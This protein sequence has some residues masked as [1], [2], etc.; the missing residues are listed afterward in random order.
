MM[1]ISGKPLLVCWLGAWLALRVGHLASPLNGFLHV[2]WA[3][4]QH[5]G[6]ALANSL[7]DEPGE[8]P[9]IFYNLVL[10]V[11]QYCVTIL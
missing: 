5:N 1:Q 4:S 11:T 9:V 2:V 6:W 3:S 10:E 8:G 7:S